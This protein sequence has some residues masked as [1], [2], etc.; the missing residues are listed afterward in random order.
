[1]NYAQ[2]IIREVRIRYSQSAVEHGLQPG[3]SIQLRL[4]KS[5]LVN[6]QHRAHMRHGLDH[7]VQ[8]Q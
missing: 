1:M 2:A 4:L 5:M 8:I 7:V 3:S 6:L